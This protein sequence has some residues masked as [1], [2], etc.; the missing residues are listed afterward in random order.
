MDETKGSFETKSV[1][2][3]MRQLLD[4]NAYIIG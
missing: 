2:T 1:L 4:W 3:F